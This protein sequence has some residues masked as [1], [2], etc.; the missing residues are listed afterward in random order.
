MPIFALIDANSFYASCE[1]AFDPRLKNRPVV[2]LSNN[3]GCIVA[4]NAQ[5]KALDAHINHLGDGGYRAARSQSMMFQPYFKV[6]KLLKQHNT[7]VFSSNYEL[8]A[9][10]SRRLHSTLGE[11]SPHQE[12]Y[13]IDESF[14]EL[15]TLPIDNLSD[16]ARHIKQHIQQTLG[17]PVAVGIGSTKTL[18]KLANHLAKK[19][20][21]L[22]GVLDLNALSTPTLQTLLQQVKVGNVWGVGRRLSEQLETQGILTAFDLQ[23]A[24]PKQIR[25]R[26]SVVVERIV[27]ELNGQSCLALH[28]HHPNKQQIV[29]SRSFG[30][31]VQERDA[32]KQAVASYTAIAA[33]KLR[34][35]GSVCQS[36]GVSIFTPRF[37]NQLPQY[38][39]SYQIALI[40]PTDNTVLLSKIA[41]KALQHIWRDGYF[42]QKA[43]VTLG[44]IQPKGALQTDLF[45]ANPRYSGNPKADALMQVMDGL[46]RRFGKHCVQLANSGLQSQTWRMK[47]EHTSPRY[48]TRWQELPKAKAVH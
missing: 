33:Q 29:S 17:L 21:D 14:L 44:G 43:A 3:D 16:Y 12:I 48:T 39:N 22:N 6:A 28:E 10:M 24:R 7:A 32:M 20:P 47:R 27:A 40:Y 37:Q 11:F 25:R 42:Y 35:Q 34:Q 36:I 4:A 45:A 5:A 2:V 38:S 30:Q 26:F 9:D 19:R 46:N 15:S 31:L 18:A 23:Q 13:S 41:L 1:M 8:Y